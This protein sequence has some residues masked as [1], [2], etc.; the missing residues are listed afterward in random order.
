ELDRDAP[1]ARLAAPEVDVRNLDALCAR[2]R[3]GGIGATGVGGDTRGADQ[4]VV[5]GQHDVV[6][7]DAAVVSGDPEQVDHDARA[8]GRLDHRDARGRTGADLDATLAEAV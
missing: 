3:L 5:D 2:D 7:V 8:S 6:A 1:F 4:A